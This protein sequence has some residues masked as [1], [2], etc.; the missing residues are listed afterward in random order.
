[1]AYRFTPHESVGENVHR[2]AADQLDRALQELT[3]GVKAD[4]VEAIHAARKALKKERSLLRLGRAALPRGERRRLNADLRDVAR[5]L[6]ATRD[7][8]VMLSALDATGDRYAGQVPATTFDAVRAH[9]KD[10][11]EA[12]RGAE[13]G[14]GAV[15]DAVTELRDARVRMERQV[16]RGDGFK[17]LAP[18]LV[19]SYER[20]RRAM[21][22]AQRAPSDENLHEWRKRAK[23]LWYHLRLL[24]DIAPNTMSGQ[25]DEA[26]ALADLLGDDHDLAVLTATLTA[27]APEVPHDLGPLLAIVRHRR[28][29]LEE[30]AK[31][32][33]ARL[34]AESPS[35]F[36]K[37]IR[38]YWKATRAQERARRARRPAQLAQQGREA[39]VV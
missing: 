10:Q 36:A 37:R 11:Q 9:L 19:R 16:V 18:G 29:E 8:D 31:W 33:G 26:H 14:S 30:Q 13:A 25:I 1:M 38:R 7:A 20:G 21:R 2:V 39:A 28:D 15:P 3:D 34:Y 27:L 32:A 4:P 35:A 23:D 6:G 12:T 5:R 22:R 17:A 24:R